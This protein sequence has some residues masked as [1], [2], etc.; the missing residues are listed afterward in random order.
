MY[1]RLRLPRHLSPSVRSVRVPKYNR[2]LLGGSAILL[3]GGLGASNSLQSSSFWGNGNTQT[4][5]QRD[6]AYQQTL[7]NLPEITLA[8]VEKHSNMKAGVWVMYE[9]LIYDITD[10]IKSHPGGPEKILMAAGGSLEPFWNM[11]TIHKEKAQVQAIL[12]SHVIGRLA[13]KDMAE[14][15]E[16]IS[17]HE[18]PYENEPRRHAL[19]KANT[20]SEKPLNAEMPVELGDQFITP[21][22]FWYIRHHHAVPDID[23][24]EYRLQVTGLGLETREYTLEELKTLFPPATETITLQCAGNRRSGLNAIAPTAGLNWGTRAISTATWTGARLCDVLAHAG[25]QPEHTPDASNVWFQGA[26][27]PY[28]AS[29]PMRKAMSR[30]GDVLLAYQMNGVDLPRDHGFP[31][32][33]VVPGHLGARSVKWVETVVTSSEESPSTWQSGSPYRHYPPTLKSLKGVDISQYPAVQETPVQSALLS[34]RQ[35]QQVRLSPE[36]TIDVSG[37]A[38]SGGGAGIEG[39]SVSADGGQNWTRATLHAPPSGLVDQAHDQVSNR[40][41]AWRLWSARVPISS[42][43]SD[44]A[45]SVKL[46]CKA[47]DSHHNT[48]PSEAAPLW[49]LRGI[50]N[51]SWHSVQVKVQDRE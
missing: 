7:A 33:A 14:V 26:D 28:D 24:T 36:G 8:E 29:I 45:G 40:C 19:L 9:G 12:R 15:K 18:D 5:M 30:E 48:Q 50:L 10:F 1:K 44:T 42:A 3:L 38:W 20:L 39:V 32:R 46:V 11:Y 17:Y 34:P 43:V 25:F 51:N 21:N 13:Q 49:N 31:V 37:Y 4:E 35:G 27:L 16:D 23:P 22:E 41:W 6:H 2:F 47:T